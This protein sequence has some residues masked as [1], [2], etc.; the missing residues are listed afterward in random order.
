ME[1]YV[2]ITNTDIERIIDKE[3]DRTGFKGVFVDVVTFD[4]FREIRLE[5]NAGGSQSCKLEYQNIINTILRFNLTDYQAN[6][7]LKNVQFIIEEAQRLHS[8]YVN[9]KRIEEDINSVV[10]D[11]FYLTERLNLEPES[12]LDFLKDLKKKKDEL[13]SLV[14]ELDETKDD[15]NEEYESLQQQVMDKKKEIDTFISDMILSTITI[16]KK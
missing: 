6:V 4:T 15:E 10:M 1:R 8:I 14:E 3:T 7:L 9:A 16:D 11:Y 13:K 5:Y 12:L 2:K